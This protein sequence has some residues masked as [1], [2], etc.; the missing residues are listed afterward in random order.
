MRKLPQTDGQP[1]FERRW[2]QHMDMF[3]HLTETHIRCQ[4]KREVRSQAMASGDGS[5]LELIKQ[6]RLQHCRTRNSPRSSATC[7]YLCVRSIR[8]RSDRSRRGRGKC[9][10]TPERRRRPNSGSSRGGGQAAQEEDRQFQGHRSMSGRRCA[11]STI[12]RGRTV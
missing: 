5:A 3:Q 6:E 8:A 2:Q 1:E 10:R 12:T 11:P 4:L 9:S 7:I